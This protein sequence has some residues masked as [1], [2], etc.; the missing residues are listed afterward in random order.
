MSVGV[1]GDYATHH[2]ERGGEF[3]QMELTTSARF[4]ASA[5][6]VQWPSGASVTSLPQTTAMYR[7]H[8]STP[9]PPCQ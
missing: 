6:P 4:V 2:R 1:D 7:V 8:P 5:E 9:V 3:H